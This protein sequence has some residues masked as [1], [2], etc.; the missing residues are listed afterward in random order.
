MR[1]FKAEDFKVDTLDS[2]DVL[3]IRRRG[4]GRQCFCLEDF[5][6][7]ERA[8]KDGV[9]ENGGFEDTALDL[10]LQSWQQ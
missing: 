9:V 4:T 6:P 10:C 3:S 7:E 8:L 1:V 5:A 2:S